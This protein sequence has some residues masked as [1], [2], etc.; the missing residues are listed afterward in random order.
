MR[1]HVEFL[2]LLKYFTFAINSTAIL[3][4]KI[5]DVCN[6]VLIKLVYYIFINYIMVS[7]LKVKYLDDESF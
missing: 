3:N 6:Y 7:Y 1:F 4:S 5:F 2:N